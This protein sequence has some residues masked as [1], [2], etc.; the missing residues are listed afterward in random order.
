MSFKYPGSNTYALKDV[1][2]LLKPGETIAIAGQSGSGKTTLI[3]LLA[4][5]Y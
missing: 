3:N 2:F 5:A 1:S 4:E